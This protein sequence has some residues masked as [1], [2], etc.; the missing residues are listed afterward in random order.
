MFIFAIKNIRK[1]KN[2]TLYELSKKTKISR[3]YLIELENNKKT[4]PTLATLNKI[5]SALKVNV[6]EL[7]YSEVE[8]ESLR[9]EMY[10]RIDKFGLNSK[11]VLEVSQIIDLLVNIKMNE[12]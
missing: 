12:N 7:F 2:M 1:S 10:K 8:I 11:E 4:N 6:K 3:S 5:A 9:K